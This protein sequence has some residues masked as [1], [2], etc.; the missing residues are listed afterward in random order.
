LALVAVIQPVP[1]EARSLYIDLPIMIAFA[2]V[3]VPIMLRGMIVIRNEGLFLV[4]GMAAF[5]A[6]QLYAAMFAG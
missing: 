6:W 1:V 2:A 3:L 5:L 4:A